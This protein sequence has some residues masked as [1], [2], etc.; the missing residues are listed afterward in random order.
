L[1]LQILLYPG[2]HY[3]QSIVWKQLLQFAFSHGALNQTSLSSL[4]VRMTGMAL[5]WSGAT[6]ALSAAQKR[7]IQY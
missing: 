4:V 2:P 6:T 7:A 5:G 1:T 3:P